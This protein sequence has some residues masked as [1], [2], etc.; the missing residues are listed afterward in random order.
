MC[1]SSDASVPYDRPNLSKNYLAGNAPEEWIPLR[2]SAFYREHD[3]EL[4]LGAE[5]TTID[6]RNRQV[7]LADGSRH[8]YDALL[9]ATGAEPVRLPIAGAELPHVHVLRTLN[10]CRA[11]V[12]R[13]C[14][15]EGRFV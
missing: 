3:I 1:D 9:L 14:A 11:I 12:R 4:E 13:L 6:T 15:R 7:E 2:D 10:D 5:V 8:G